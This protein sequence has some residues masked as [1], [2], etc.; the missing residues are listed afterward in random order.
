MCVAVVVD[1]KAPIPAKNLQAMHDANPHGAG[2]AWQSK[3]IIQ[4]RK[5]LTWQQ[6]NEVQDRLPRPFFM[7]YRIATQGGRIPEL[8]HPFPL[9]EQ[10]LLGELKGTAPAILMHN[11]TWQNFRQ[12]MRD[13]QKE[14]S[15]S[16]TQ[17]A[18]WVA[19]YYEDV[20]AEVSWSN[21]IMR[22][23]KGAEPQITLR[24]R[25]MEFEGNQYSNEHWKRELTPKFYYSHSRSNFY[26]W[27]TPTPPPA[28]PALSHQKSKVLEGR[29]KGSTPYEKARA[30]Y[31]A[32]KNKTTEEK[33]NEQAWGKE[34]LF[35]KDALKAEQA[36][37][38][39]KSVPC[40][41]CGIEITQIPCQCADTP[42]I[43]Q[44]KE[45]MSCDTSHVNA[46]LW[47][48]ESCYHMW[49]ETDP[50]LIDEQVDYDRDGVPAMGL[51][52]DSFDAYED[53]TLSG[54]QPGDG[55]LVDDYI[56]QQEIRNQGIRIVPDSDV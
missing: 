32:S 48:C 39:S 42:P 14:G 19:G 50:S 16:D 40:E 3:G 33:V 1:S 21:A 5:G 28:K 27:E 17:I 34:E 45:C 12:W 15:V 18:A 11:G 24:G 51:G 44:C 47:M 26:D 29:K 56:R 43:P 20:L 30:R 10:A 41:D 4:F 22:A 9:G 6:I 2:I 35:T 7:H 8:T 49:E 55:R 13:D 52:L 37:L 54:D 53:L 31:E 38:G 25:W 36:K 46:A 23:V